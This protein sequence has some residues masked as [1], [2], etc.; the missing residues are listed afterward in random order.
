MRF[1]KLLA[2]GF[3]VLAVGIVV[4]AP[5]QP[6][7]V[8]DVSLAAG[9]T[10]ALAVSNAEIASD[11]S[12]DMRCHCDPGSHCK[13]CKHGHL[14]HLCC[15]PDTSLESAASAVEPAASVIK[16]NDPAPSHDIE[17]GSGPSM[18]NLCFKCAPGHR[19]GLCG[20]M[21]CCKPI[22]TEE[23]GVNKR[24]DATSNDIALASDQDSRPPCFLKCMPGRHCV[25]C[26]NGKPCCKPWH[27]EELDISPTEQAA[28]VIERDDT[29]TPVLDIDQPLFSC[30]PKCLSYQI[31]VRRCNT[32]GCKPY[33]QNPRSPQSIDDINRPLT[34]KAIDS[35]PVAALAND[36]SARADT[37]SPWASDPHGL[38]VGLDWCNPRCGDGQDCYLWLRDAPYTY[39]A[40]KSRVIETAPTVNDQGPSDG[41]R[42]VGGIVDPSKCGSCA[43]GQKCWEFMFS[44]AVIHYCK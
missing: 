2:L 15:I 11:P 38:P 20:Q 26:D 17:L 40:A 43:A 24:D 5:T 7:Q 13:W 18:N 29:T 39:C 22:H 23:T 37:A 34:A 1:S 28:A 30:Q 10:S 42:T 27:A 32:E 8:N 25:Y 16:R 31:C 6:G 9:T 4:P 41:Q 12:T 21:P 36:I 14:R 3:A 33:C 35:S 44:G 19:C